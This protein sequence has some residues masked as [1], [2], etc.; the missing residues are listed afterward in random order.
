MTMRR[1]N[2]EVYLVAGRLVAAEGYVFTDKVFADPM[3]ADLWLCLD[4]DG[5]LFRAYVPFDWKQ[6]I[7]GTRCPK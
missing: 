3:D 6:Y 1:C 2:G 4:D 7:R 5:R